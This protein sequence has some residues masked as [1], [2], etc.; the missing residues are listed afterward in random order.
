M[1]IKLTRAQYQ[2]I[3]VALAVATASLWI[4]LRYFRRTFPEASLELRVDRADSEA[5]AR[6][7]L[8]AR[9]L[10]VEGY[11]HTA[12]F[13]Y[14][15]YEK[16][17]L[18][19]TLGL[20][21]LNQLTAGPVHLWRW[22]N[23]W[24]KPQQQEE[25]SVD[26]SPD[27]QVVRFSHVIPE[28]QAGA[29]LDVASA[30][31]IAEAFLVDVMKRHLDSLE[32]LESQTKKRPART[33]CT[34]TW[35]QKDVNLGQGS[36][37]IF[38]SVSG[39]AVSDYSEFVKI[40][41]Q[42]SRDYEKLRSRNDSAQTVDEVF[43][44][45]LTVAMIVM[46]IM[47]LRD[48]D[49]PVKTALGFALLGAI[50]YFLS[51][52]NTFPLA[53]SA[54]RTTDSYSSFVASYFTGSTLSALGVATFIFFLV[55]AAEPEYRAAFPKMI[56]LRRSLSWKGL[57]TRSF[58]LANVVGLAMAFFFF[59]Y[60]TLFYFFANKLGAWAPSDI[61]F[62]NELNT[63]IPW[64]GVLFMGFLPAVSEELQFRAFAI[65]FLAKFV[66]S[67][68]V[69]I[70]LA[71]FNWGFLH[72]AYPNEPFFI[73]GVEVGLGGIV[74]GFV[75]LRFGIVA[76]LI[77]HYSV[78][79]LYSAFL[80]LRS[81]NHY[82]AGSGAIT[83]GIMLIPLTVALVAYLRTGTFEDETAMANAEQSTPKP[84]HPPE[85][86][87]VMAESDYRPLSRE[88]LVLAAVLA[89]VFLA[90]ALIPLYRFGE[91]VKVKMTAQDSIRAADAY[92]RSRGID[93]SKYRR[94]VQLL[95]DVSSETIRYFVEHLSIKRADQVYRSA[96]QMLGWEV[97]YFR[98]LEI[99]EHH[100][101]FDA[102]NTKFTDY[103][104]SLDEDAPGASLEPGPARELAEKAL[105][106]HDYRLT[107]FELQDSRSEK[108]KAREDYTFVWQAKPGDPRNV[109]EALYRV[110][111]DI[112][113]AEVIGVSDRFKLPEEWERQQSKS[114]LANSILGAVS[115]LL[116]I[117]IVTR[118]IILFVIQLRSGALHW[119]A[120]VGVGAAVTVLA[121]L[122]EFNAFSNI[123]RSYSTSIPLSTFW[124]QRGAGLLLLPIL[125]GLGAWVLI[126]L[127]FSLFPD[128]QH[129]LRRSIT[130][131]WRR[132]AIVGSVLAVALAAA[133]NKLGT[134]LT[135]L[136]PT[137]FP[138]GTA[139]APGNLDTW[140]PA[141][142]YQ[143]SAMSGS[144]VMT[145]AL[146]LAI[147]VF[148]SGWSRKAWWMWIGLF[149]LVISLGPAGAHS[150]REFLVVWAYAAASFAFVVWIAVT[151]LRGNPLAYLAAIFGLLVAQP[152]EVL[153]SQAAKVY[154]WNGVLLGGLSILI[155]GWLLLPDL[156]ADKNRQF[157]S[158]SS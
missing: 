112:A 72:S 60:Q 69:A 125:A 79:A 111:V 84:S 115:A 36:L 147:A 63:R 41:E 6:Q 12:I 77:W 140:S 75:M 122:S 88:R 26:V 40:P 127:V 52:L 145:A 151:F 31:V 18:E 81:P 87:T 108:R 46:L 86:E 132:D 20:E 21:R 67:L 124:L 133:F 32:L 131:A 55:A 98:P 61:P 74:I 139:L 109:G 155:L 82:L 68:P 83:A 11:R 22:S 37:R 45:L 43:F 101:F 44:Y 78:D 102:T 91:G 19:R 42:W 85:T 59:A 142:G 114:G 8:I 128:A 80:L 154:V 1:P 5:I 66:R 27:G 15:D 103:R 29:N 53:E 141:L 2:V 158:A 48:R 62:T 92:L 95:D 70:V 138:P 28:G 14:G 130:R 121:L 39:N 106:E 56:S 126:T 94:V 58:F 117:I 123:E 104:H 96:T 33:D 35:K 97:R 54:Y 47:R 24:F 113:G 17:Y 93:P 137:Y 100:I 50:L 99:E 4:S 107:D 129:L 7:F 71:A 73:R 38:V 9:G 149:A 65:P 156:S 89:V 152:T 49:V 64:M 10:R 105:V 120:T 143:F 57:R 51:Q 13:S 135:M 144:V 134:L 3:A 153:L 34:F 146:G 136:L 110:R 90:T 118:A 16:L 30:R 119:R 76:T 148:R 23:R 116:G 157:P 25:Y 150:V